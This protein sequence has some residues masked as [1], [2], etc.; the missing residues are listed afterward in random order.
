MNLF[1]KCIV[2]SPPHSIFFDKFIGLKS[3]LFCKD[4][5]NIFINPSPAY[6]ETEKGE[7]EKETLA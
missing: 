4:S 1:D 6:R 3:T 7:E 5:A 2:L